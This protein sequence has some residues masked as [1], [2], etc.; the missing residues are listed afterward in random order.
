MGPQRQV[1]DATYYLALLRAKTSELKAE[2]TKLGNESGALNAEN[3]TYLTFE[4]RA[5]TLASQLKDR[6]V[7]CCTVKLH[8]EKDVT[9]LQIKTHS[10]LTLR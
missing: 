5:E 4:R 9:K 7:T 1:Q 8:F 2:I 6:Q 10:L 3:A